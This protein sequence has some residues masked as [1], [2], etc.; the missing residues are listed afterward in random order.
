MTER[1]QGLSD[2]YCLWAIEHL[3]IAERFLE[4]CHDS[5]NVHMYELA[6]AVHAARAKWLDDPDYARAYVLLGQGRAHDWETAYHERNPEPGI[7][8]S[9]MPKRVRRKK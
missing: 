7:I 3:R 9:A 1:N 2:L 6:G 5:S 8:E 4:E